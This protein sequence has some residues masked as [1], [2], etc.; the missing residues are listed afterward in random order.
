MKLTS[1]VTKLARLGR[2]EVT[3]D[4]G[5]EI[6][7]RLA[8][9]DVNTEDLKGS[10]LELAKSTIKKVCAQHRAPGREKTAAVGNCPRC[11]GNALTNTKLATGV[12]AQFCEQCRVVIPA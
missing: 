3:P 8:M 7:S 6:R 5:R 1:L 9:A 10:E 4:A 12:C 11:N 2:I